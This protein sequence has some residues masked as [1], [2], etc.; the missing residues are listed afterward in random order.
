[1]KEIVVGYADRKKIK[2]AVPKSKFIRMKE[3]GEFIVLSL[4]VIVHLFIF[5]YIPML[6]IVLAFKNFRFDKGIFGSDWIGLNNFMFL[7]TSQD[8]WR[9]TLNTIG[10]NLMFIFSGLVCSVTFALMLYEITNKNY[11]KLYQTVIIL[12]SFLSWVVVGYMAYILLNPQ[13]G[14]LNKILEAAG[15]EP[16]SWYSE[17]SYW[18]VILAISNIW[19]NVGLGSIIYYAGLMGINQEYYEAADIDGAGK[20][21]KALKISIPNILPLMVIMTILAIGGIFRSDFG[22]FFNLTRNVG[23]LY[24]TTD[25]IDT[26][27]YRALRV[28][29]DIGMSSAAGLYQ[30]I[31]G[32]IMILVT[33]A[34]VRRIQPE[35]ALF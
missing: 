2:A 33:N 19:K 4:P 5:S 11:V 9:I 16:V 17:P 32:F 29:G 8:A 24:P 12:P 23:S 15:A 13:L 14:V 1:V 18:P 7:F 25:V 10:L 3:N 21:Q 27:V 28:V 34:I 6:G 22:M 35:N 26:Y 30:S 31:V 20:F